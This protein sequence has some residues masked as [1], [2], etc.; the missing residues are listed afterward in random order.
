MKKQIQ[1]NRSINSSLIN[2]IAGYWLC[3]VSLALLPS[4]LASKID[5]SDAPLN[6][7]FIA[8]DDLRPNL[9]C[10]GAADMKTPHMDRLASRGLLF[11]RAY[12]QIASCG[13]SRASLLTGRRPDTTTVFDNR[14]GFRTQLPDIVT[15]PQHFRTNGYHTRSIG[16]V[17]HGI[18][19]GEVNDDPLSWSEPAWRPQGIQYRTKEGILTLHQ[20]YPKQFPD[21]E[22]LAEKMQG[23]RRFKG[24]AVEAPD[25]GDSDLMDGRTADQAIAVMRQIKD[26]PFFLAVGFVKPHAPYVAPKRYF[27]LYDPENFTLPM[28]DHLPQGAPVQAHNNDSR[29][30]RGY[31]GIAKDGPI[32]EE[33]IRWVV[34]GYNACVSYVDAQVGRLMNELDTLGLGEQTVIVL[35]GDHGYHLGHNGLWCKNTNF[36]AA[37]RVPL[38]VSS[39]KARARGQTSDALV[40]LV[41][42]YPT[43][44]DLC[45]LP[46]SKDVHGT[47]FSPLLDQPDLIWKKTAFS[48]TPRPYTRPGEAMGRSIRTDRYRFIEWTGT[49]ISEPIYELYD[50]KGDLPEKINLAQQSEYQATVKDLKRLL[51]AGR[52]RE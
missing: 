3:W 31:A 14:R 32:P 11:R 46:V 42:L 39:P 36:E 21:P 6:V 17:F 2:C 41:D 43:L 25:V 50:Y 28:V 26:K 34:H 40:E 38:I 1:I 29:E 10:Y 5:A 44:V 23:M 13:P 22:D 8:I 16:K 45:S 48:Q 19:T 35:W 47:S 20:R 12:C 24:L 4:G 33:Q 9:A 15:L 7:L 51:H 18:F 30:L 49:K 52:R 37:T 27:D